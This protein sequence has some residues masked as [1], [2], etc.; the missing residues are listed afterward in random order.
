VAVRIGA[1]LLPGGGLLSNAE[2]CNGNVLSNGVTSSCPG[3]AVTC[4]VSRPGVR[5]HGHVCVIGRRVRRPEKPAS[6]SAERHYAPG[7]APGVEGG[8]A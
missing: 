7:E 3:Q 4:S 6:T 2:S 5:G 1:V 8:M